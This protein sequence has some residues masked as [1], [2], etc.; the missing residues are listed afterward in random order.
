MSIKNNSIVIK[1]MDIM[2]YNMWTVIT[3]KYLQIVALGRGNLW[4]IRRVSDWPKVDPTAEL[5]GHVGPI[6]HIHMDSYKIV[7]GGPDND[8]VNVWDVDTGRQTN[9]LLCSAP[10]REPVYGC[11]ALAVDGCRMVT[12]G[13]VSPESTAVIIRDFRSAT[14]HLASTCDVSLG[15]SEASSAVSKFWDP[16]SGNGSEQVNWE[17]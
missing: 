9:S 4:D 11:S 10:D 13:A 12:A 16:Q 1:K 15:E 14:D 8:C 3:N 17:E 6:K 5:H 7:T 2:F